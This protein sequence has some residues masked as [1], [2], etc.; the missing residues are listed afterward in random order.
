MRN[1][2]RSLAGGIKPSAYGTESCSLRHLASAN[3]T[4]H[5]F[6]PQ[7]SIFLAII[8]QK[9]PGCNVIPQ[10]AEENPMWYDIQKGGESMKDIPIFSTDWGVASLIFKEIPYKE[11]AYVKVQDVQPGHIR[12]LCD[13]CAQ[14]CRAAGAEIV[15]ASGH[16]DLEC[17]PY[18]GSVLT[19]RLN[20]TEQEEPPANLFPVTDQT[21]TRWRSIYN[22]KMRQV[23]FATTMSFYDE[24]QILSSGGAYFVHHDGELLGVGWLDD[25]KILLVAAVK[26]GAGSRVMNTL[27][28]LVEG[29]DV[30]VEVA[31]TNERAI[32]LYEK[33]GFIRSRE[34]LRWHHVG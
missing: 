11:I 1:F 6:S 5:G 4:S 33:M 26:P 9:F 8:S 3:I 15:L 22:D 7:G 21:V 13:E 29:A 27:L 23:D 16:P 12:D 18:Y 32:R 2:N 19:M 31:S 28:S 10:L 17:Y 20:L 30:T 14:F 34:V 24:K 25:T